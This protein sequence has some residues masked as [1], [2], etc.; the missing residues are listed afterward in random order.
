MKQDLQQHSQRSLHHRYDL[1]FSP[2][3]SIL[4][5]LLIIFSSFAIIFLINIHPTLPKV[6]LFACYS[7]VCSFI[8]VMLLFSEPP[9]FTCVFLIRLSVSGFYTMQLNLI[10][11]V[12][13]IFRGVECY[14]TYFE[15]LADGTN[16]IYH[17]LALL[18]RAGKY[19][20]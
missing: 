11:I 12:V 17:A 6:I 14:P 15:G 20:V 4:Q 18:Y 13:M 7:V 8:A 9:I 2:F 16:A 10:V 3:I 19:F 5:P 1:A